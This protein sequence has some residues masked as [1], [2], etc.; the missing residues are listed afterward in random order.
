MAL[1]ESPRAPAP[2]RAVAA[3][4]ARA[5]SPRLGVAAGIAAVA[6]FYVAAYGDA[7]GT[8][9]SFD[10]Y[11]VLARTATMPGHG[12]GDVARWFGFDHTGFVLYRPFS[13]VAYYALLRA[14]FGYDAAGYHAVHLALHV[15]NATLVFA[16]ATA[17]L[18][19]RWRGFLTALL[20]ATA[21]GHV[22]AAYWVA[23]ATMTLTATAYLLALWGW[24]ARGWRLGVLPIFAVALLSAEHAVTLPAVLT[25]A[26]VLLEGRWPDRRDAR[27]LVPLWTIAVG[28]AAAKL[29]YLQA[30]PVG[31]VMRDSGYAMTANPLR[32]LDNLGRYAGFASSLLYPAIAPGGGVSSTGARVA[33]VASVA[34]A[35][36]L[37]IVARPGRAVPRTLRAAAFGA[38]AFPVFLAPVLCL[39]DHVYGFYVGLAAVGAALAIVGTLAS[40]P[41]VGTGAAAAVA[42]AALVVQLT[43]GARAAREERGFQFYRTFTRSAASWID[44]VAALDRGR[45]DLDEVVVRWSWLTGLVFEN[46]AYRLFT[47]DLR[48]RV[49]VTRN[50]EPVIPDRAMLV[51]EPVP[52]P[53][54]RPFPGREPRW[55]FLRARAPF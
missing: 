12:P 55:D 42:A 31:I 41:R 37:A 35:V 8:F 54:S 23:L 40:V 32:W 33:G 14:V 28:Y 15:V 19:G 39:A 36:A 44:T 18:G 48:L 5:W 2:E 24:V 21:P 3:P 49:H 4:R 45:P 11:W 52:S 43:S 9:F 10:D 51:E 6:L 53:P 46:D 7:T 30:S 38:V 50:A 47:P 27:A 29:W 16:L 1:A 22:L 13:T 25:L 20:Y 17:A 26:V 34:A